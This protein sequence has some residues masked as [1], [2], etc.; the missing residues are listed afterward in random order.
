M[1]SAGH[2]TEATHGQVLEADT[3]PGSIL[4]VEG[5]FNLKAAHLGHLSC[6]YQYWFL[7][8]AKLDLLCVRAQLSRARFEHL[9]PWSL[10]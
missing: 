8:P 10:A 3:A 4:N 9:G 1:I 7:G 2:L 5:N 6:L